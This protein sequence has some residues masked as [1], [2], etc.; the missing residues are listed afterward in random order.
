MAGQA[1][2]YELLIADFLRAQAIANSARANYQDILRTL[3]QTADEK[4]LVSLTQAEDSALAYYADPNP[5]TQRDFEATTQALLDSNLDQQL[6]EELQ[7]QLRLLKA[8]ADSLAISE[9]PGNTPRL[10]NAGSA[11]LNAAIAGGN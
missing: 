7:I 1:Q 6:L 11:N 5:D 8:S 4:L 2:D 3:P 9:Y 10:P